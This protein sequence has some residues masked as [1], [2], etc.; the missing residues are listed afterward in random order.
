MSSF[1]SACIND[2]P[3]VARFLRYEEDTE[4]VAD[5]LAAGHDAGAARALEYLQAPRQRLHQHKVPIRFLWNRPRVVEGG[6]GRPDATQVAM[7]DIARDVRPHE[8]LQVAGEGSARLPSARGPG[9][10]ELRKNSI[11][12]QAWPE[13]RQAPLNGENGG[14]LVGRGPAA[15]ALLGRRPDEF[16]VAA[17]S[18]LIQ[19]NTSCNRRS[20]NARGRC[21]CCTRAARLLA[22]AGRHDS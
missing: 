13:G 22:A 7:D 1:H 5:G 2:E 14:G 17:A 19:R 16:K 15:A 3:I 8:I 18:R 12:G 6:V 11:H 21:R 20:C 10:E 4:F 9:R